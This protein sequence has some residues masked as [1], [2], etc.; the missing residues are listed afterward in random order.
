MNIDKVFNKYKKVIGVD[1]NQ[2]VNLKY[3]L[4]CHYTP[5]I[6]SLIENNDLNGLLELKAK[7]NPYYPK[8][9]IVATE[10]GIKT[11]NNN[12]NTK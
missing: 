3:T 7:F 8:G 12:L 2:E 10:F 5:I 4:I 1:I 9:L 6:L 11:V